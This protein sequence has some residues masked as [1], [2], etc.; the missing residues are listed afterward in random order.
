MKKIKI[1]WERVKDTLGLIGI[2]WD[3]GFML[4]ILWTF[5]LAWISGN[6]KV[7][8]WINAF[9]EATAE[10]Y[11]WFLIVPISIWGVYWYWHEAIGEESERED[12]DG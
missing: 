3:F 9:G 6:Y 5:I 12:E 11:L 7:M 4:L 2:C 1:N 8:V 10:F